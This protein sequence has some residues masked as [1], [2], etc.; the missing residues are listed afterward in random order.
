MV[1]FDSISLFGTP[2]LISFASIPDV[3]SFITGSGSGIL[4]YATLE[5]A[6]DDDAFESTKGIVPITI[7]ISRSLLAIND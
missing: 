1:K 5:A 6:V 7:G 3:Y 2:L 4:Q